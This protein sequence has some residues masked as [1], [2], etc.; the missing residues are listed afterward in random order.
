MHCGG[1]PELRLERTRDFRPSASQAE[2]R[3]AA[4]LTGVVGATFSVLFL[5]SLWM[6]RAAPRPRTPDER[7]L[8]FYSGDERRQIVL[9]GLYLLPLSA[10]A[11]IWFIAALRQWSAHSSRR[12]S[13]FI[14]TVQ[15]L[16]GIGFIILTLVAAAAMTLP[17]AIMELSAPNFDLDLAR[18]FPLLGE[19][20]LLVFGVRLSAMFVFTSTTIA[21]AAGVLPPWFRWVSLGIGVVLLL[22]YSLSIWLVVIFPGWVIAFCALIIW[23]ALGTD[24]SAFDQND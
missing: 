6:L 9:V 12:G 14:G 1:G 19:A 24:P 8:E 23:H 18:Q 2:L 3:R 22:S 10:V 16:S 15:L 7:V 20:L 5:I 21:Y 17:A 11:F 13:Q 4:V